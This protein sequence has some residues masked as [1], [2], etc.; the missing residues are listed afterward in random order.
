MHVFWPG[1]C[2]RGAGAGGRG[3]GPTKQDF[4][5]VFTYIYMHVRRDMMMSQ[6]VPG[7][8]VMEN[9]NNSMDMVV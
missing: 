1:P 6:S 7:M 3:G 8:G 4:L 9:T 2:E 5:H